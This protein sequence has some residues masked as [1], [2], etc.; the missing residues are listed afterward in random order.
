MG[1]QNT[2]RP[3]ILIV[4]DNPDDLRWLSAILQAHG[5]EV[6]ACS[7]YAAG[8]DHALHGR[9]DFVLVDQGGPTFEGHEVVK[10][11]TEEDRHT[12]VLVVARSLEMPCYLEA[13][14]MGAL[15]YLEKPVPADFLL[16][17]IETHLHSTAI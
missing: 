15:D 9:Y 1:L 7:N 12:P 17:E 3:R 10:Y 5:Y 2:P 4:D 11:A 16:R 13:M 8:A 6:D 14:Q